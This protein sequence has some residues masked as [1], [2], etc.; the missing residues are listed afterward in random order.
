MKFDIW[1]FLFQIINFIALLFILK[2]LLFRPV[3]EILEKRRD[4]VRET[5]AKADRIE[6]DA[7]ELKESYLQELRK[8]E[9][10]K[11][12]MVDEMKASVHEERRKL[13]SAAEK[14]AATEIE[15]ALSLFAMEKTRFEA[16]L[17]DRAVATVT[18]FSAN[19][20]QGIA[21]EELH[22]GIWRRFLNELERISLD[23]AERGMHGEE[24]TMEL[25]SAYPLGED[26]LGSLQSALEKGL[27]QKV[28]I[29][30]TIDKTLIAGVKL[31]SRDMVYDSS[32]AGQV[33]AFAMRLKEA[34]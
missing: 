32:L 13:L 10:I 3:R 26:E 24:V 14:E 22:R 8:L 5:V 4:I 2:R 21:D 19:L 7:L 17:Q 6:K 34:A 28:M 20:L 33:S 15:K 1:T 27:S 11:V 16:D 29:H 23:I 12:R 25:T 31:R 9:E 18:V 30:Q